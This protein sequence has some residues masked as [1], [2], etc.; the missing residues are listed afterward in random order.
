MTLTKS[1]S[2]Q[3][4]RSFASLSRWVAPRTMNLICLVTKTTNRIWVSPILSTTILNFLIFSSC[5]KWTLPCFLFFSIPLHPFIQPPAGNL[6]HTC[7]IHAQTRHE[8]TGSCVRDSGTESRSCLAIHIQDWWRVRKNMKNQ[9][10]KRGTLVLT[11]EQGAWLNLWAVPGAWHDLGKVWCA[12]FNPCKAIL[13]NSGYIY[14]SP[15]KCVLDIF[16]KDLDMENLSH[17]PGALCP[18]S[19]TY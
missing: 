3:P 16:K 9:C 12:Q 8:Q 15:L 4:L 1:S 6:T 17:D 11:G 10:W 18:L 13:L 7:P 2:F 19:Q 5:S 14:W